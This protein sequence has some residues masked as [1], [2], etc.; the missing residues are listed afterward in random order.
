MA[1]LI[2]IVLIIIFCIFVK[3]GKIQE[4]NKPENVIDRCEMFAFKEE[5]EFLKNKEEAIKSMGDADS[6]EAKNNIKDLKEIGNT[7]DKLQKLNIHLQEKFKTDFQKRIE[8]WND[9]TDWLIAMSTTYENRI[10]L[11]VMEIDDFWESN[12]EQFLKGMTI[13]TKMI[14]LADNKI[15]Q[16][17]KLNIIKSNQK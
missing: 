6:N 12:N 17:L 2:V 14:N 16:L 7:Q 1:L 5:K 11:D 8:I 9:Y 4:Q 10:H 15:V 13:E 3:S